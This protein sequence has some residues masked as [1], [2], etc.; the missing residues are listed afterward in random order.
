LGSAAA[1]VLLLAGC[2]NGDGNARRDAKAK[3]SAGT[4]AAR[5]L[6][7]AQQLDR[8]LAR[9]SAALRRGDAR[10]YAATSTG[11][12][13]A[14]D[15]RA[16]RNARGLGLRDVALTVEAI[17]IG[18]RRATMRV[19]SL[20]GLRGVAGRFGGRRRLVAVRT[21]RGWRVAREAGRR[22]RHPWEVDRYVRRREGRFVLLLP[23]GL[24]AGALGPALTG[25]HA[26][27]RR[28]L[29]RRRLKGR[30]LVVVV[31]DARRA[32]RITAGIR[33]VGGLA[34]ITDSR[35]REAGPAL[36]AVEVSSQRMIVVWPG[37]G[38]LPPE[39][40]TRVITHELTH[41]VL[42]GATS[43]RTPAW[44]IEGI[45]LYTSDDRRVA[46]A[47]TAPGRT[48][49]SALARPDRIARLSGAGQGRGYAYASSAAFYVADRYGERALERLYAA[50]GRESIR[51]RPGQ[52]RTTDR[53]LRATLGVSLRRF[54][55]DLRAWIAAG[56]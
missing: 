26:A 56:G 17:D 23:A 9:R 22:E 43:G 34:A 28:R 11:R 54:E 29:A 49:L 14:A 30:L 47:A 55:R 10:A 15:R 35:V 18:R 39:E 3:P 16:A 12:Q 32:G 36:R 27:V 2:G 51:G 5:P 8:L 44:L 20:Y 42:A 40:R 41:A 33:G 13:R 45:A 6:T 38:S 7:P 50:F 31:R 52:P 37:F 25:G 1:A 4:P 53:A 48:S 24:Q 19:R 21:A 46:E